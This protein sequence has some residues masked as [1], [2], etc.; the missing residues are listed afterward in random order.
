MNSRKKFPEMMNSQSLMKRK[1]LFLETMSSPN[2]KKTKSS[3]L[4]MRNFRN[5]RR[6][7]L[8]KKNF[9]SLKKTMKSL[10]LETMSSPNLRM[11]LEKNWKPRCLRKYL[12]T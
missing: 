8:V 5:L 6:K 2:S 9:P 7:C 4:E 3:F 1:N 11:S 12:S 10:S